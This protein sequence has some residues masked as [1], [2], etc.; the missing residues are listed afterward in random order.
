[1][2]LEGVGRTRASKLVARKLPRLIPVIDDVLRV[3][4]DIRDDDDTWHLGP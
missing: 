3:A 1:M 2:E 4:L